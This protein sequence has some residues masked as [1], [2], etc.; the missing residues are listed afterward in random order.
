LL[1]INRKHYF[2][3]LHTFVYVCNDCSHVQFIEVE[4]WSIYSHDSP[5]K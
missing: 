1:E 5:W 3:E 2:W 4:L